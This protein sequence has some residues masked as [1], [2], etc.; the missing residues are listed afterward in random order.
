MDLVRGS[1][2]ILLFAHTHRNAQSLLPLAS[3]KLTN[4]LTQPS[5]LPLDL[6]AICALE[7]D[8]LGSYSS[9]FTL[10]DEVAR[11]IFSRKLDIRPLI[12]HQFPL[13]E[14]AAAVAL[15]SAPAAN[16]LKV[17]VISL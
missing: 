2:K 12:T 14:T 3:G 4:S 7:K 5:Q 8:L 16:S 9:D 17:V 11:L 6:S 1:G 15:A 13:A 10:Q